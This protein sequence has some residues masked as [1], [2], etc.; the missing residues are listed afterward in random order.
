MYHGENRGYGARLSYYVKI[1]ASETL[2]KEDDSDKEDVSEEK[3]KDVIKSDN[4]E[5]QEAKVKWDS[6]HLKVYDGDRLI[7][8]LKQKAPDSTGLYKWTW[9]MDE[10]GVD[11]PSKRIRKR[12]NESGGVSVK[13]G[14]YK[15]VIHFGD[16]TSE[17]MI[18]VKSDPR[19]NVSQTNTNQVY[20]AYKELEG[21]QQT[22]ADAVKQLVESKT[23]AKDYQ[24]LLKKLDKKK[25][26]DEI[27][28]SKDMIKNIDSIV[29]KF[30]GKE[31]KRQGITRN[32]EVTVMQRLGQAR[33][34]VGSRQNGITSTETTLINN[35]KNAL[36]T[37]LSEINTFFNDD[38]KPY[39]TK[40]EALQIN[41]FKEIKSFKLD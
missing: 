36:E 37:V 11:Y 18:T 27:N 40:M 10:A 20:D 32:P 14:N 17:E 31:D 33:Q 41:P 24:S 38:W 22:A 23:I 21:M 12:A 8:T 26:K 39:Q 35:A 34:Y 28:A 4:E 16:Q 3:Q 9:Y 6:I 30:L 29:D 19:V 13:P 5:S 1:D 25:Y 7:R 2:N 15:M